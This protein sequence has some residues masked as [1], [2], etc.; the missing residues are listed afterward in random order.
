[1]FD[2]SDLRSHRVGKSSVRR[3]NQG[4]E[5]GTQLTVP[6]RSAC[7][8]VAASSAQNTGWALAT[9]SACDAIANPSLFRLDIPVGRLKS[10]VGMSVERAAGG[11]IGWDRGRAPVE[12]GDAAAGG[13]GDRRGGSR[14][15]KWRRSNRLLA[16]GEYSNDDSERCSTPLDHGGSTFGCGYSGEL[17]GRRSPLVTPKP[18][19]GE[20]RTRTL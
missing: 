19:T 1:L 3:S 18:S 14:S 16:G 20:A 15:G 13:I 12:V 9:H 10:R 5:N 2:L 7:P 11:G 6:R 17:G 8:L 4:D